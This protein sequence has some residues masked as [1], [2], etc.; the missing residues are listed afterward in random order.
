[1]YES[2]PRRVVHSHVG[3][4]AKNATEERMRNITAT[5]N[6]VKERLQRTGVTTGK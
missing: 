4:G 1:M 6:D 3:I 2:A 5:P